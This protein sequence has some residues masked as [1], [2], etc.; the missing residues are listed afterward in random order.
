[1][2]VQTVGVLQLQAVQH[3]LANMNVNFDTNI[4]IANMTR[5]NEVTGLSS[6]LP[7]PTVVQKVCIVHVGACCG[8][9]VLVWVLPQ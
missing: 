9:G 7:M 1:M 5:E 2:S 4:F 8:G 3:C 6:Q